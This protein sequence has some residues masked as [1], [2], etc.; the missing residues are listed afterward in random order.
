MAG[1]LLRAKENAFQRV[2]DISGWFHRTEAGLVERYESSCG[3]V[4]QVLVRDPHVG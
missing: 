1:P 3:R 4:W 2:G